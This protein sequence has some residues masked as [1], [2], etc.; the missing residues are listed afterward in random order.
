LID[1]KHKI[2]TGTRRYTGE[3]GTAFFTED[4]HQHFQPQAD[5]VDRAG[6]A[7]SSG[8]WHQ[9]KNASYVEGIE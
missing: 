8:K 6:T 9:S 1:D 4:E 2:S 3:P 5:L 7:F